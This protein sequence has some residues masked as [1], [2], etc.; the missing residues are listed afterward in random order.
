MALE[1]N[2]TC[3]TAEAGSDLSAA[4]YTFVAMAS[5][6]AVDQTAN[7]T[8]AILGVLQN[9]P[10][11]GRAATVAVAGVTKLVAAAAIAA[12]AEIAVQTGG[13]CRTASTG[14]RIHGVALTASAA[15]GDI[16]EVLLLPN[17]KLAA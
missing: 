6:G 9:D 12:G 4:Q 7:A 3:I 13:K 17:G 5:D 1:S 10:A 8:A 16:I 15:D 14:L 11:A 2:L